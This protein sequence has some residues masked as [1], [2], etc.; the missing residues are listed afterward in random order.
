MD[1][2]V[3]EG[4]W[5][6]RGIRVVAHTK[7]LSA[8]RLPCRFFHAHFLI[9]GGRGSAFPIQYF[10]TISPCPLII[11]Y[12]ALLYLQ[13]VPVLLFYLR[14]LASSGFPELLVD[15]EMGNLL[16]IINYFFSFSTSFEGIAHLWSPCSPAFTRSFSFSYP[17]LAIPAVGGLIPCPAVHITPFP[18]VRNVFYSWCTGIPFF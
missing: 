10:P 9:E 11:C 8:Q 13:F 16:I 14:H 18:A 6:R 12:S 7:V 17:H 1:N 5:R 4:A 3:L 2:G 15:N